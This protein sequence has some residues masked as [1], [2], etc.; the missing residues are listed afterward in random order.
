MVH[1]VAKFH[2]GQLLYNR[3]TK[4]D[5]FISRVFEEQGMLTYEVWVP[6]DSSSWDSGH[7]ISHWLEDTVK[8]SGNKG[9]G[10]P[11]PN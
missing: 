7:W 4:E 10:S 6:K 1:R 9:L 5:G 11:L 2:L 8:L 3:T